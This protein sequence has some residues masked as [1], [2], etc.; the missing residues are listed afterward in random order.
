MATL[1]LGECWEVRRRVSNRAKSEY[2]TAVPCKNS[3]QARMSL[4]RS[5]A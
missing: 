3:L 2:S 1:K 5:T 4:V